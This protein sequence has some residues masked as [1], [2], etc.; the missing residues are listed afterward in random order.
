MN[1]SFFILYLLILVNNL[2]FQKLIRHLM[3]HFVMNN[4][5]FIQMIK[6]LFHHFPQRGKKT[7]DDLD[8][9]LIMKFLT[10]KIMMNI[11]L[12][13]MRWSYWRTSKGNKTMNTHGGK[14]E[15]KPP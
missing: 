7:N 3:Q 8:I 2:C 10:N 1:Y 9:E 15:Y 14:H 11:Q 4:N 13:N 12:V 6:K 5:S